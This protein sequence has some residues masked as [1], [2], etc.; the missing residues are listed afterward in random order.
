MLDLKQDNIPDPGG[1]SPVS[2][3]FIGDGVFEL[4]V[5]E[6]LVKTGGMPAGKLHTLAVGRVKASAQAA[7]YDAVLEACD[8]EE[9]SILRRGRN[10]S[11]SRIPRS[12]TP[13]EYHKATAIEALFGYLYLLGRLDRLHFLF[14]RMEEV[15]AGECGKGNQL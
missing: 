9:R 10:V 14:E 8:E 1:M 15:T 11:L 13:E 12:C 2:L 7:A 5:R 3:A 4:M 6:Q